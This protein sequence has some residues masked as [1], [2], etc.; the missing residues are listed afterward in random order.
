[1]IFRRQVRLCAAVS[2]A[3]ATPAT[4]EREVETLEPTSAWHLDYGVEYCSLVRTFGSDEAP[5]VFRVDSFGNLPFYDVTLVGAQVP[6]GWQ[7]YD[8][9]LQGSADAKRRDFYAYPGVTD[10]GASIKGVYT[11]TA[12]EFISPEQ[13]KR[14][15]PFGMPMILG[16]VVDQAYE[17]ATDRLD[18]LFRGG[19]T[20]SLKTGSL[21]APMKAM[22]TCID[23]LQRQWGVAPETRRNLYKVPAPAKMI[24]RDLWNFYRGSGLYRE[25]A[26]MVP[27]RVKVAADGSASDCVVQAPSV[28]KEL[29]KA[30]CDLFSKDYRP[31]EDAENRPVES[32]Y[33]S[34]IMFVPIR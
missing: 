22:R 30:V 25:Q 29:G 23:D 13:R 9:A 16:D 1:M 28:S 17:A 18:F 3:I 7:V 34:T 27:F 6:E 24:G 2:L 10:G 19:K 15:R 12:K 26:G 31:A 8:M 5:L 4:A 14:G 20:L 11:F 33:Q 21:A 32:I